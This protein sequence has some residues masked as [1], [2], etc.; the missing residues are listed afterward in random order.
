MSLPYVTV[1]TGVSNC[2]PSVPVAVVYHADGL[3]KEARVF[4]HPPRLTVVDDSVVRAAPLK[5]FLSGLGDTLAKKY[6]ARISALESTSIFLVQ[7]GLEIADM[8]GN[9]I[10]DSGKEAVS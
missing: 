6:E 9:R 4:S 2:A 3:Y 5:Y 10:L 8:I 1:P 7:V